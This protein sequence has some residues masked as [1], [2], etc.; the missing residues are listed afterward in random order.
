MVKLKKLLKRNL[1]IILNESEK[2]NSVSFSEAVNSIKSTLLN[3]VKSHLVS[4]VPVGVF[5]SGGI[6]S[7]LISLFVSNSNEEQDVKLLT[8]GFPEEEFS[9]VKYSRIVAEKT[10]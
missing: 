3:S 8:V 6:D 2:G 1:S 9:E 10:A 7:S 5:L 4:D